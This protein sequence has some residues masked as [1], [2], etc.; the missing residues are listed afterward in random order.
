LE[1]EGV[2]SDYETMLAV[3]NNGYPD[4]ANLIRGVALAQRLRKDH[5]AHVDRR[6]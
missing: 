3:A 6:R 2:R 4:D 5:A 1:R